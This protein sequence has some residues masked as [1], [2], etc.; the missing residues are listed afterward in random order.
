VEWIG[1]ELKE[2][3]NEGKQEEKEMSRVENGHEK[4]CHTNGLSEMTHD[5]LKCSLEFL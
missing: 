2:E 4:K 5:D 1:T 3:R